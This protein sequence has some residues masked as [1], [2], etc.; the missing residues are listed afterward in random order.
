MDLREGNRSSRSIKS[1]TLKAYKG[2]EITIS[3]SA[4][5]SSRYLIILY[6]T[7]DD[8]D[9]NFA[10]VT[11]YFLCKVW[12]LKRL[13]TLFRRYP[14]YICYTFFD[15]CVFYLSVSRIQSFSQDSIFEKSFDICL[16]FFIFFFLFAYYF[17]KD[18][19]SNLDATEKNILLIAWKKI[20]LSFQR[21]RQWNVQQ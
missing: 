15:K 8:D 1:Y 6:A 16:S 2:H 10:Q 11:K 5:I 4:L 21:N 12:I 18:I 14:I 19:Y 7:H 3:W 13:L 17:S 20:E 9:T